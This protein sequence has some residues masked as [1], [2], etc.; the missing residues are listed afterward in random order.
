MLTVGT[1]PKIRAD[2]VAFRLASPFVFER[3]D[4]DARYALHQAYEEAEAFRHGQVGTEHLLLGLLSIGSGNA[5]DALTS[6]GAT[7]EGCRAK[8]IEAAANKRRPAQAGELTLTDRAARSLERATRL[9]L[10]QRSAEV[11]PEHVLMSVLD[12]EGTAGQVL[13]GLLVD[14]ARVRAALESPAANG[15]ARATY[16]APAPGSGATASGAKAPHCPRCDTELGSALAHE[17]VRSKGDDGVELRWVFAYC[18]SCG[19][20]LSGYQLTK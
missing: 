14:P 16:T 10:R 12:V 9:S 7:L 6:C 17:V 13:R 2:R 11:S 3:F 4:D 18:T 15:A 8:V 19:A 20:A 5:K 1:E